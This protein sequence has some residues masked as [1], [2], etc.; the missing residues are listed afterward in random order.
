MMIEIDGLQY[1]VT[2]GYIHDIEP[3]KLERLL[4]AVRKREVVQVDDEYDA[5]LVPDDM[6][7]S[8]DEF[9]DIITV[10]GIQWRPIHTTS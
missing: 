8:E 3:A 4:D 5:V 1:E 9:M 6:H 10:S 7:V 2:G